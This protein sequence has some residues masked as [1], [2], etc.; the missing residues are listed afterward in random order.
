MKLDDNITE[1][2][3]PEVCDIHLLYMGNYVFTELKRKLYSAP[4]PLSIVTDLMQQIQAMKKSV[5][6]EVPTPSN[7]SNTP[8]KASTV[9]ATTEQTIMLGI[10]DEQN[11]S[12]SGTN[13]QYASSNKTSDII[14]VT[15]TAVVGTTSV[16]TNPVPVY[17]QPVFPAA[18]QIL[19]LYPHLSEEEDNSSEKS[20][21]T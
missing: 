13:E 21:S 15:Q 2:H 8:N 3:L 12:M 4:K 7:L 17:S 6:T 14:D 11:S 1:S 18:K 16:D 9:I 19:P 10:N 5:S 20:L